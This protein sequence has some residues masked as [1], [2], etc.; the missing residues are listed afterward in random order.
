M[1]KPSLPPTDFREITLSALERE[2][3]R[4]NWDCAES[5]KLKKERRDKRY[6]N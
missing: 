5:L 6:S 3:V 1:G 2:L 4:E